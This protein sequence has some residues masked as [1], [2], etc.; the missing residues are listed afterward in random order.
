MKSNDEVEK[1]RASIPGPV[2]G[3]E[4]WKATITEEIVR[5]IRKLHSSGYGYLRIGRVFNLSAGH[6]HRIVKRKAWAHVV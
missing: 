3:A 6:V 4:H 1:L 5:E 2:R